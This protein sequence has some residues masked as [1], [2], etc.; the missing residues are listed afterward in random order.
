MELC[1]AIM[2]LI[3]RQHHET[4]MVPAACILWLLLVWQFASLL[5]AHL[6]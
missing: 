2:M 3:I 4:P 5:S 1:M 6:I